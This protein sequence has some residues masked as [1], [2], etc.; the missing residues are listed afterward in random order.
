[1]TGGNPCNEREN[2]TNP[3]N[4]DARNAARAIRN[5]FPATMTGTRNILEVAATAA[6]DLPD[7]IEKQLEILKRLTPALTMAV[8]TIEARLEVLEGRPEVDLQKLFNF[9]KGFGF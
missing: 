5:Q 6:A 1:M 7:G 3:E 8:L 2:M 4:E 9:L